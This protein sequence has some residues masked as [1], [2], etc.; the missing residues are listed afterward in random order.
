MINCLKKLNNQHNQQT[1]ISGLAT[2][3]VTAVQDKIPNVSDLVKKI[4]YDAEIKDIEGT[5]FATSD[6]SRL[7]SNTLDAKIKY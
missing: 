6:Y 1:S 5:N 4:G 2:T 7:M 3:D